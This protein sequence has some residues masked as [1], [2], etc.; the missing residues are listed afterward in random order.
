MAEDVQVLVLVKL[1]EAKEATINALTG[2][3]RAKCEDYRDGK[4]TSDV[5]EGIDEAIELERTM[6]EGYARALEARRAAVR[7]PEV[8]DVADDRRACRGR[9]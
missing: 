4:I 8:D 5:L 3:R 7:R 1:V 2:Y 9:R 6:A